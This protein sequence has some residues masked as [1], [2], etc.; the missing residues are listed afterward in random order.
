MHKKGAR[1]NDF[2]SLQ[3]AAHRIAD[4]ILTETVPLLGLIDAEYRQDYCGNRIGA[5]SPERTRRF[6]ASDASGGE[7]VEGNDLPRAAADHV[8][9]R[10]IGF[11]GIAGS[12]LKPC[13]N[14]LA[15]TVEGAEIVPEPESERLTEAPEVFR[16]LLGTVPC[17]PAREQCLQLGV[18]RR[19]RIQRAI[20]GRPIGVVQY[21]QPL[22]QEDLRRPAPRGG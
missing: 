22:A 4:Q 16:H 20:K 11:D 12:G 2:G 8:H 13:G 14:G 21:K 7:S 10:G 17:G 1:P 19:R 3:C 15:P 9:S 5:V 18:R 6:A